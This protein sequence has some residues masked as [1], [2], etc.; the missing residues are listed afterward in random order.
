[1]RTCIRIFSVVTFL[2]VIFT[3]SNVFAKWYYNEV[4]DPENIAFFLQEFVFAPEEILPGTAEDSK[5]EVNHQSILYEIL[6]SSKYGLNKANVLPSNMGKYDDMIVCYENGISGGNM[7]NIPRAG[8][9]GFVITC[10]RENGKIVSYYLY[11]FEEFDDVENGLA[12][13][14]YRTLIQQSE[15]GGDWYA[16]SS[17]K[18][19]VVLGSDSVDRLKGNNYILP[20]A[21]V[22][23]EWTP[24]S[25]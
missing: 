18:G 15:G 2:T 17:A 25:V 12:L 10:T 11:T 7:N 19:Y 20:S 16:P 8:N 6:N 23:G 1:M 5:L 9:L 24:P 4:T 22:K 13:V 14:V 21:W 3:T